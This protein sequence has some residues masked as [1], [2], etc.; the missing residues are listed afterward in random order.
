MADEGQLYEP[1][2]IEDLDEDNL[3]DLEYPP[4]QP[5]GVEDPTVD[6]KVRDSITEREQRSIP[7]AAP[8]TALPAQPPEP[9]PIVLVAPDQG[10]G[11]DLE[12][13]E[14]A[15]RAD[16]GVP[17]SDRLANE[18]VPPPAEETAVHIAEE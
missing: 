14:V 2:P 8:G 9:E 18:E 10:F 7:E 12:D 6:S 5:L 3:D 11:P 4:E 1:D 13:A 15:D 17:G 16:P